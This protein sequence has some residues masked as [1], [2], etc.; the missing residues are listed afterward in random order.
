MT[1]KEFLA[2]AWFLI[3]MAA[4]CVPILANCAGYPRSIQGSIDLEVGETIDGD[5]SKPSETVSKE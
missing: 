2:A 4:L 1:I 5:P 3:L